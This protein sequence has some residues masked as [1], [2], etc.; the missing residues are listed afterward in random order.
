MKR[1]NKKNNKKK[2]N[3]KFLLLVIV[4][5]TL[6]FFSGSS[7]FIPR[8]I[9]QESISYSTFLDMLEG[10]DIKEVTLNEGNREISFVL[11]GNEY[12]TVFPSTET[13]R[14]QIFE[15]GVDVDL[16]SSWRFS[17]IFGTLVWILIIYMIGT[18]LFSKK[19]MKGLTP[20][21]DAGSV[22]KA[23]KETKGNEI[24]LDS[25]A[26]HDEVKEDLRAII[27]TLKN[28]DKYKQMGA[29][30][31]K[32]A[33]LYGPPGTGKTLL[34]KAISGEAGVSFIH[35]NGSDF[36]RM[37]SGAGSMAV[38]SLFS[39]ARANSPAI[40]FID[41]ID[42][43]GGKRGSGFSES[44]RE[45][46][47]NSLLNELDGFNS[48]DGVFVIA[49]TNRLENLDTAL[50]RTGRLDKHIKVGLPNAKEREKLFDLYGKEKKFADDV[51]MK[52]LSR[53]CSGFSGSDVESLLNESAIIATSK[54]LEEINKDC[55]DDAFYKIV[56][57]GHK[58]KVKTNDFHRKTVAYHEAGHAVAT[59][60]FTNNEVIRITTIS[61][62]SG[63]GGF[64]AHSPKDE[65]IENSIETMKDLIGSVKVSYAGRIAETI[66]NN[67]NK[68]LLT[69][70]AQQDIQMATKTLRLMVEKLGMVDD[71]GLVDISQFKEDELVLG[72]VRSLAKEIYK[73]TEVELRKEFDRIE[74]VAEILLE[75]EEIET[76]DFEV[77]FNG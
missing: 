54:G 67:N 42:A 39:K 32:G 25:V 22:V 27:D 8:G 49:A 45:Q 9:Q 72:K 55:I 13:A 38:K 28:P 34:A 3:K 12:Q 37:F 20:N 40:I 58:K 70:G 18:T 44:E 10:E 14:T 53:V 43:V 64:A 65:E 30:T 24:T 60:L 73:E 29:K 62:S 57:K 35:A 2:I 17:D 41:E 66:L 21:T 36:V 76:D 19:G 6:I 61:S 71:I 4:G 68:E 48:L 23:D 5:V 69:I 75:K 16:E 26:G 7:F 15:S 46:T 1:K 74:R 52:K 11:D 51:S 77:A 50:I 47:I 59:K 33:V 31:P 63:V 56:T